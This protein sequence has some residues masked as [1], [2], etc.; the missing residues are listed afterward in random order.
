[1]RKVSDFSKLEAGKLN[2]KKV[3]LIQIYYSAQFK[4]SLNWKQW[5]KTPLTLVGNDL[6]ARTVFTGRPVATYRNVSTN[7]LSKL[8]PNYP[9]REKILS[10]GEVGRKRP[11]CGKLWTQDRD[12]CRSAEACLREFDSEDTL[13]PE[14]WGDGLGFAIVQRGWI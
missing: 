9:W 1:M 8:I 12:E 14:V 7:L 13:F 11:N 2:C 5:K 4:I 3:L 6:A 10:S